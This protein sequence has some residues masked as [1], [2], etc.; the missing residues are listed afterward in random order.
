MTAVTDYRAAFTD[1]FELERAQAYP[2]MD[3]LVQRFGFALDRTRLEDAARVLAC[4][5][6]VHPPN[7]QH[8]RLLYAV[9][10]SYLR[11][12]PGPVT[13]LDIGTAKG[14]SA[15]CLLSAL[16]DAGVA[17]KVTSLD[18]IDPAARVRRNTV[19]ELDGLKTLAETLAP[20][21]ETHA[22]EFLKSTGVAWLS[23]YKKRVH[24]AFVDGKH[25]GIIVEHEGRL[26]AERQIAGDVVV[27]DDVH[28]P[29]VW[30]AV[31]RLSDAYTIERIDLLP[32]RAYAI[33]RRRG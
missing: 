18:V 12:M 4:P 3:A 14:F 2:V 10:R 1:A 13:L 23:V 5:L 32:H 17:G 15:W 26:L 21:P 7:W 25:T 30:T 9:A 29:D 6:K 22:I 24:L 19:A 20:W 27:F 31:G 8:G 28:I 33:A 11:E 16:N